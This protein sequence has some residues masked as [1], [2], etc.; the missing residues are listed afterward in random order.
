M[1]AEIR[2]GAGHDEKV[3]LRLAK[4]DEADVFGEFLVDAERRQAASMAHPIRR[5]RFVVS[6]GLRR[7]M[8]SACTGLPAAEIRFVD[9]GGKPRAEGIEGWDFNLSH[10]GH[11]VA[12]AAGHGCVGVD[13]EQHREVRDMESIVAR[14]FH[15][16]E[17]AVWNALPS[18]QRGD[19]FFLLWSAREAAMKCAGLG[20]ARGLSL[21]RVEPA[22]L[23]KGEGRV[24][25]GDLSF[26]ARSLDLLASYSLVICR[27]EIPSI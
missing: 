17:A 22:F 12:V 2:F 21:T 5:A 3:F 11:H 26:A 23:E 1:N 19:A 25:V 7:Q 24:V 15:A 13:L 4:L 6:R 16:D 18:A 14:Y 20:L 9:D 10:A 8:L 27:A